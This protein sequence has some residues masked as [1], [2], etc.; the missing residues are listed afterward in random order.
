MIDPK[1]CDFVKKIQQ[2]PMKK[3]DNLTIGQ[4]YELQDHLIECQ[5][6]WVIVEEIDAKYKDTP[7]DPNSGWSKAQYN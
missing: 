6:C 5:E 3:I 2:D 4:Y 1:W 7:E